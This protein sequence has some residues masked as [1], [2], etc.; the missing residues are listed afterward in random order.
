M[1]PLDKIANRWTDEENE[2]FENLSDSEDIFQLELTGNKKT[3][4]Q[5]EN[6]KSPS[7]TK[8]EERLKNWDGKSQLNFEI[9]EG[10]E[11]KKYDDLLEGENVPEELPAIGQMVLYKS[12]KIT[13]FISGSFLNQYGLIVSDRAK[14]VFDNLNIG[15][16]KYYPLEV[17][18]KNEVFKDYWFLR[19]TVKVG[20]YVDFRKT[21]FYTQKGL[22]NYSTREPIA[23]N[24][25]QE[26][27][28]YHHKVQGQD[29]YINAA[30][31]Y[32]NT[33]F[34]QYDIFLSKRFGIHGIFISNRLKQAL[35]L[36][37]GV[38]IKTTKRIKN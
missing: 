36:L 14:N 35:S 38:E 21:S 25:I 3:G 23:L 2:F 32:L 1:H 7:V 33:D 19:I 13:D 28:S 12:S 16:H 34:P 17:V 24:S 6:W 5:I 29:I 26:F 15:N 9:Q 37:S 4:D 8:M 10:G 22:L 18:H 31:L 27:E 30:E 11:V 20:D